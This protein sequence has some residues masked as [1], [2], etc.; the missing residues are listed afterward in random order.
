MQNSNRKMV[1]SWDESLHT[2]ISTPKS[3]Q[4]FDLHDKK[5]ANSVSRRGN[6][7]YNSISNI[8][9]PKQHRS[10][11]LDLSIFTTACAPHVE[12]AS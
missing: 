6:G 10:S 9:L 5:Y 12:E 8:K 4:L 3:T 11:I 7:R 1:T 2:E